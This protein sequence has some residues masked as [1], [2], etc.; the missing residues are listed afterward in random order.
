[1]EPFLKR[2]KKGSQEV[3]SSASGGGRSAD[4]R[5]K[6]MQAAAHAAEAQMDP[7]GRKCAPVRVGMWNLAAVEGTTGLRDKFA[8]GINCGR[9][10]SGT[11]ARVT[12]GQGHAFKGSK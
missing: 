11:R 4:L 9:S 7:D 1:M 6:R 3:A 8:T 12:Q 5:G 2:L 10:R